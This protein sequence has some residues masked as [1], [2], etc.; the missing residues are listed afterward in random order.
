MGRIEPP[1]GRRK[2]RNARGAIAADVGDCVILNLVWFDANEGPIA[3]RI[4]II[5]IAPLD[6]IGAECWPPDALRCTRKDECDT[7]RDYRCARRGVA[8]ERRD[9]FEEILVCE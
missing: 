2:G 4:G 5:D 3:R 1:R 8:G 9:E 7:F 6:L